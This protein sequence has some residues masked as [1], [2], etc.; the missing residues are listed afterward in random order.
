[1]LSDEV[2][3]KI[4]FKDCTIEMGITSYNTEDIA[5]FCNFVA[6]KAAE[7]G[8]E[9]YVGNETRMEEA[10]SV[11]HLISTPIIGNEPFYVMAKGQSDQS[12]E[13]AKELT[14]FICSWSRDK[15]P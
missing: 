14:G 3:E 8:G 5:I 4:R 12:R 7:L 10:T 11:M 2:E 15:R 13:S 9:L 1:M 6:G